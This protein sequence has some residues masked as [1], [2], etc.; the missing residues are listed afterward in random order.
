DFV[1]ADVAGEVRVARQKTGVVFFLRFDSCGN[2][3]LI[4][5][6]PHF[7]FGAEGES[8]APD[9]KAHRTLE[10]AEVRVDRGWSLGAN[11]DQSSALIRRHEE[12]DAELLEDRREVRRGDGTKGRFAG[13]GEDS[14]R[15]PIDVV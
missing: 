8:S 4:A 10:H 15:A 13:I 2:I 3:A 12:R 14:A 9:G 7:A 11:D 6:V 5:V 1:N